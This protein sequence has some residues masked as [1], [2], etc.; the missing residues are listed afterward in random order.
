VNS[1]SKTLNLDLLF[2]LTPLAFLCSLLRLYLL[3]CLPPCSRLRRGR[4]PKNMCQ[5]LFVLRF[6]DFQRSLLMG[7]FPLSLAL[8]YFSLPSVLSTFVVITEHT[9]PVP[10]G[11]QFTLTFFFGDDY[12]SFTPP[13]FHIA[14]LYTDCSPPS[15]P[16]L[17][18]PEAK[19]CRPSVLLESSRNPFGFFGSF[20]SPGTSLAK[21]GES[22]PTLSSYNLAKFLFSR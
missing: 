2:L 3:L 6:P 12:A 10:Q 14:N 18:H 7:T 4:D 13:P 19:N 17:K 9:I 22:S 11:P 8:V 20:P 5:V 15:P 1:I 16:A 21:P